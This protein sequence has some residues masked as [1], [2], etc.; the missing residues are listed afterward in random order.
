MSHKARQ[1]PAAVEPPP[2]PEQIPT[3]HQFAEEWWIRNERQFSEN[4]QLDY[5]WRLESHLLPFYK[6]HRLDAITFDLVEHY[7]A[8]KLAEDDPLSPRSINMTAT[9]LA[10]ILEGAVEREL[11]ARNPAKGRGRRVRERAPR[12]S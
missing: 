11:I 4:T 2:E 5:R 8:G 7:I 12:R 6:D 3:F 10:A 1:P 9:L